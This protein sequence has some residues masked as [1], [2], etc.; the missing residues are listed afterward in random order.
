MPQINC[1]P[2]GNLPTAP[3][4]NR[5]YTPIV[6][7]DFDFVSFYWYVNNNVD[8]ILMVLFNSWIKLIYITLIK[9]HN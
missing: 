4:Q 9:D 3:H 2:D 1:K 7:G 5:Y 8:L 6:D